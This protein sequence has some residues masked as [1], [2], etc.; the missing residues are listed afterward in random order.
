MVELYFQALNLHDPSLIVRLYHPDAVHITPARVIQ[1]S[2][3]IQAWFSSLFNE[4]LPQARFT[5]THTSQ[6]GNTR[7]FNWIAQSGNT[8]VTNGSDTIGIMDGKI[9][10]HYSN[11]TVSS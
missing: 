7:H 5:L 1:G 11:F 2:Q 4:L 10:Y 9:A 8:A 6:S 3:A